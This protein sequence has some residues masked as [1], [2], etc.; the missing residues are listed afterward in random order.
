MSGE[1]FYTANHDG[2]RSPGYVFFI[3]SPF[4]P[5]G[6]QIEMSNGLGASTNRTCYRYK[7]AMLNHEGRG[8]QGFKTIVAEEQLPPARGRDATAAPSQTGCGDSREPSVAPTIC[9]PRR[10]SIRSSRSPAASRPRRWPIGRRT[11][12]AQDDALVAHVQPG[13]PAAPR[14]V[15]AAAADEIRYETGGGPLPA[16]S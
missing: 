9:A 2:A 15:H 12:A 6:L 5:D 14:V 10:S 13:T 1:N 4:C 7:D 11:A 8:F 3:V 16:R